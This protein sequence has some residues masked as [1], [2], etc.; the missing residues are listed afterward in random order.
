MRLTANKYSLFVLFGL[1]VY[2]FYIEPYMINIKNIDIQS[3][4]LAELLKGYKVVQISDLHISSYSRREI[5][6]IEILN[7]IDPDIIF[8]TG[9]A[10]SWGEDFNPVSQFFDNMKAKIG[11]YG[12]LGNA[13]YS[14][15]E[16]MCILCHAPKSK[17]L[18][19]NSPIKFLRNDA[20]VINFNNSDNSKLAIIGIDDYVTGKDHLELALDQISNEIPKI[21]LSHSPD[22]FEE[23]VENRMDLVLAGHTHGGQIYLFSFIKSMLA[24]FKGIKRPYSKGIYR[25]GETVMYVNSGI[26]TSIVPVR[27]GVPPEITIYKFH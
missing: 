17:T 13:D 15:P 20:Y 18:R 27:L 4:K 22:I 3:S 9:D 1:L 6:A 8:I 23:A 2:G 16:G 21:L 14:N 24:W 26:G 25:K 5:K 7:D 19:K 11:I 10:V 12:V